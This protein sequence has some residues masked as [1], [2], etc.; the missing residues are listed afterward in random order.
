MG[1]VTPKNISECPSCGAEIR[2]KKTPYLGQLVSC[3]RCD[4][5]LEVV[6]RSPIELAWAG[7]ELFDEIE[8]DRTFSDY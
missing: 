7:E 6:Q 8:D 4:T 2:F 3:R 5:R 1:L